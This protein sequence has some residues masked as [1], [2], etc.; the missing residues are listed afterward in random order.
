MISV[1]GPRPATTPI[2]ANVTNE[3][4]TNQ[5]TARLLGQGWQNHEPAELVVTIVSD[6]TVY[7]HAPPG[8]M[9]A[10][11]S[12]CAVTHTISLHLIPPGPTGLP[13]EEQLL[14]VD[15]NAGQI[16]IEKTMAVHRSIQGFQLS[17]IMNVTRLNSCDG[18]IDALKILT[19]YGNV[20]NQIVYQVMNNTPW[21][22]WLQSHDNKPSNEEEWQICNLLVKALP[23]IST[24]AKRYDQRNELRVNITPQAIREAVSG[25]GWKSLIARGP[26]TIAR[27]EQWLIEMLF[28]AGG[29]DMPHTRVLPHYDVRPKTPDEERRKK[30]AVV[31]APNTVPPLYLFSKLQGISHK[32]SYFDMYGTN[33]II[34]FTSTTNDFIQRKVSEMKPGHALGLASE[35]VNFSKKVKRSDGQEFE[36]IED[37][38]NIKYTIIPITDS[39]IEGFK[40]HVAKTLDSASTYLQAASKGKAKLESEIFSFAQ[41]ASPL[42]APASAAEIDALDKAVKEEGDQHLAESTTKHAPLVEITH[43][44]RLLVTKH[45]DKVAELLASRK[46]EDQAPPPTPPASVTSDQTSKKTPRTSK[47]AANKAKAALLTK[48]YEE[49][50]KISAASASTS[51]ER[52]CFSADF[53]REKSGAAMGKSLCLTLGGDRFNGSFTREKGHD[54]VSKLVLTF[55][56]AGNTIQTPVGLN[57]IPGDYGELQ[58][59]HLINTKFCEVR[60]PSYLDQEVSS[61][62]AYLKNLFVLFGRALLEGTLVDGVDNWNEK[63][64]SWTPDVSCEAVVEPASMVYDR[65]TSSA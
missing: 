26:I 63:A 56:I 2:W 52:K 10:V 31:P 40:T 64:S 13:H 45:K 29:P 49:V 33:G 15:A 12:V 30:E 48:V 19:E 25:D 43:E 14:Q 27:I 8:T 34:V 59:D 7:V 4:G 51:S 55:M 50:N 5:V 47:T 44:Q 3:A 6:I 65:A 60:Y 21:C 37:E 32:L 39:L 1:V 53:I 35:V 58:S 22:E 28:K 24:M 38:S 46:E 23:S 20:A 18:Q 42:C 36:V 17:H 54:G 62:N 61:L 16:F 41:P 9:V 11:A 57:D